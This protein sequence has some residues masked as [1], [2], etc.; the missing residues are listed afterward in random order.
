LQLDTNHPNFPHYIAVEGPIG[1]G[2]TSFTKR[3]AATFNYETVLEKPETN[4]FLERFY[5]NRRQAALPT[6]LF[7]LF[8]RSRQIQ[9]MRQGD[10]FE[11]VRI[12]DFLLEKDR[13]FAEINLDRDELELYDNVYNHLA[14]EAPTPDLVIY[15]Q[16]PVPVLLDRIQLRGVA[17]EQ[18]IEKKYLAQLVDAYTRFFHYYDAAPLLIVNAAE[19]DLVNSDADYEALVTYLSTV[20]RARHYYNPTPSMV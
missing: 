16:A 20:K 6:Q 5:Q 3:L 19:I 18:Q 11:P 14:I 8:E 10:M 9:E 1:V 7:F 2:K 13:L 17:A 12:A 15:L 4:P